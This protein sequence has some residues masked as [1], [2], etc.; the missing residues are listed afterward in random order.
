MLNLQKI[1]RVLAVI[2]Y[3]IFFSLSFANVFIQSSDERDLSTWRV[4]ISHATELRENQNSTV[5]YCVFIIEVQRLD[6]NN[7]R[8][9]FIFTFKKKK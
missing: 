1:Q 3:V 8:N 4:H 6:A 5:K 2:V 7:G 9:S